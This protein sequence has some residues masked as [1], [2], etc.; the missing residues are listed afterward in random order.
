MLMTSLRLELDQRR[1]CVDGEKEEKEVDR[2]FEW[3]VFS[4]PSSRDGNDA[5]FFSSGE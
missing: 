5:D 4:F 3:F 1:R 2:V